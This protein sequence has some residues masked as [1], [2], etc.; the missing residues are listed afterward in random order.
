MMSAMPSQA[1]IS[2]Q[3]AR[4]AAIKASSAHAAPHAVKTWT[5]KAAMVRGLADFRTSRV[6]SIGVIPR[7][8]A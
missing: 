8:A 4:T 6:G 5:E 3:A 7:R 2:G 1:N